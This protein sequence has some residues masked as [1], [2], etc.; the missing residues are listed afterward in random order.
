M[1]KLVLG[2]AMLIVGACQAEEIDMVEV[3]AAGMDAEQDTQPEETEEQTVGESD[4]QGVSNPNPSTNVNSPPAEPASPLAPLPDERDEQTSRLAV[5]SRCTCTV[6]DE[7]DFEYG[8]LL[9]GKYRFYCKYDKSA[10]TII[11]FDALLGAANFRCFCP[12][13]HYYFDEI[14]TKGK[15][16]C[17]AGKRN[18]S[19]IW[20]CPL[21]QTEK[22]EP[23][24]LSE[25]H[26]TTECHWSGEP[27]HSCNCS[28]TPG[29]WHISFTF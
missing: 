13:T 12:T 21:E 27:Y 3:D 9:Q 4:A 28:V 1:L 6:V 14:D 2:A 17:L 19:T 11:H 8:E 15:A 16:E 26:F 5:E 24:V 22:V 29:V 18:L 23:G 7:A 25:D 10:P 20:D